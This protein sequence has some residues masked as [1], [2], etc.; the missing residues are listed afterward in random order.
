MDDRILT[1]AQHSVLGWIEEGEGGG[2][3]A[4]RLL[5]LFDVSRCGLASIKLFAAALG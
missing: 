1:C 4:K 5:G 2:P 3:D